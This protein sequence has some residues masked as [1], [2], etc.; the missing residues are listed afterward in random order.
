MQQAVAARWTRRRRQYFQI[1]TLL[2]NMF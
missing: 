1:E 2:K